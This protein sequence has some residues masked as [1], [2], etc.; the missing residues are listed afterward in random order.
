MTAQPAKTTATELVDMF[1]DFAI[2]TV[3]EQDGVWVMYRGDVEFLI[4]RNGNRK[5]RKLFT[6]AV[7]K[8]KRALDS[9]G[10]A[11]E[12]KAEELLIDVM[13]KTILLNWRG[14][15]AIQGTVTEYSEAAAKKLLAMPMFREW[16]NDQANDIAAYKAVQEN[17]DA[18]N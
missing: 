15:L 1:A 9:K 12:A 5:Y 17:E 8:N 10:D 7:E 11:A 2:N 3:K 13:A 6:N 16:V 4:A 18:G 14:S